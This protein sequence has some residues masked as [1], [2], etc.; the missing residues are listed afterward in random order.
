MTRYPVLGV[1]CGRARVHGTGQGFGGVGFEVL[2]E[3]ALSGELLA[4]PV[5]LVTSHS[6]VSVHLVVHQTLL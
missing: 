4:A 2:C 3:D 5:T 1:E 6:E